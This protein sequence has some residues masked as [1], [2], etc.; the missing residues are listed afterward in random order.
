M[1][2]PIIRNVSRRT[3]SRRAM[4]RGAGVAL[5]LPWLESLAPTARAQAA[6]APKRFITIFFPN[7][8]VPQ[9]WVPATAGVGAAW[10]LSPILEPLTPLKSKVAVL[11]N[12]ENYTPW[13]DVFNDDGQSHGRRPGCF[14]TAAD[15][16]SIQNANNGQDMNTISADQVIAQNPMYSNLTPLASLQLGCGTSENACDGPPCSYSR[17]IT[18]ASDTQPLDP[19]VDPGAAF[20]RIVGSAGAVGGGGGAAG[21]G[22]A[23][24]PL[25]EQRRA[26]NQSVLDAVKENTATVQG[27]LGASDKA[28]MDQFLEAIRASEQRIVAVSSTMQG[29]TPTT[30]DGYTRPTLTAQFNLENTPGGYNKGDHMDVMNDLI[31]MAL[32]TDTTRIITH[33][34]EHERSE[35]E[36][37][38]VTQREFSDAGSTEKAGTCNNYHGAQHGDQMEFA[39]ITHWNVQKVAD[40]A[41]RLSM[42]EDGPGVSVLDNS[43]I[44]LASCMDGGGHF[45]DRIPVA[46]IGGAGGAFKMDQHIA[47][48]ANP[49]DRAMRDMWFTIMNGY[50]GVGATDFGH[51]AKGTPISMISELLA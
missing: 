25:A 43:I 7:G 34:C 51:N 17:N 2:N 13:K 47:F 8:T 9:Y 6:G 15:V 20:D 49:N 21:A 11:S 12:I 28:K 38:H 4:L 24:D 39:T 48:P 41:T 44:V 36:Y 40:L 33:M 22:N 32:E 26:L 14:L 29:G 45:G 5:S 50:F 27:L 42:I 16:L 35:F 46:L 10:A 3:F 31:V 30:V 1:K 19:E 37:N 23:P 18:W